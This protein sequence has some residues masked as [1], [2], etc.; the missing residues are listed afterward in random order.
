[1][2]AFIALLKKE[3]LENIRSGRLL[4]VL[5]LFTCF[6]IMNPAIAKMTP[7][8]M[9]I[10]S[11][12]LAESGMVI[13]GVEVDALTSWTQFFKNIPMALIVFVVIYASSFTGEY[14]SGTLT[15]LLTKGVARYKVLMAK[16]AI[17]LSLWT[18]SYYLCFGITY[19]YNAYFW[20]NSIAAELGASVVLWWLFGIW[21][22]CAL[23]FLSAVCSS[24]S[25]VLIG[26]GGG[27]LAFYLLSF[28][29][30]VGDYSPAKLMGAS[31][32]IFGAVGAARFTGCVI[33]SVLLCIIFLAAAVP[34]LNRKQL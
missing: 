7:W 14:S 24:S 21:V 6:G 4:L 9:E 18:V 11:E 27:V 8:I 16:T 22:L 15:L 5:I 20:D 32:I 25:V 13:V 2:R 12:E 10:M 23:I 19:A 28:I 29:P 30:K 31:G 1:M 3:M 17:I 26:T 33:V 34:L